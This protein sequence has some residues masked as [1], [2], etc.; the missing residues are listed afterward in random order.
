M[1]KKTVTVSIKRYDD[2]KSVVQAIAILGQGMPISREL[3][4]L[5]KKLMKEGI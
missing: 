2:M 1:L 4:V 3:D 5:C